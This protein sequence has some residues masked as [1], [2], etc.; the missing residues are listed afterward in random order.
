VSPSSGSA[1]AEQMTEKGGELLNGGWGREEMG[2]GFGVA[3]LG[4]GFGWG[5]EGGGGGGGR[6]SS[7]HPAGWP[8]PVLLKPEERH[9]TPQQMKHTAPPHP[10]GP[11]PKHGPTDR[12]TVNE[13]RWLNEGKQRQ[14]GSSGGVV[15]LSSVTPGQSCLWLC[16]WDFQALNQTWLS[17]VPRNSWLVSLRLFHSNLQKQCL[18]LPFLF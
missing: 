7:F 10:Q 5:V 13:F 1:V 11:L 8:A 2:C 3:G 6:L 17:S 16:G 12:K 4:E 18:V 14:L 9:R 15:Q